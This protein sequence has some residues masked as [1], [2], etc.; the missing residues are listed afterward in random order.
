MKRILC[1][2]LAFLI[3]SIEGAYAV[4]EGILEGEIFVVTEGAEN[5]RL[6]LVEVQVFPENEIKQHIADRE[7]LAKTEMPEFTEELEPYDK[8]IAQADKEIE[9]Y[10]AGLAESRAQL[11]R[12]GRYIDIGKQ[13]QR[14]IE[15]GEAGRERAV[16]TKE[17]LAKEKEAQRARLRDGWPNSRFYFKKLPA[18]KFSTRTNSDG[19]F[20]FTIP[21]TGKFAV[22]ASATRK[23]ASKT[24]FYFWLIRISLDG[25]DSVSIILGNH[26]LA[27]SGSDDSFI[28][29]KLD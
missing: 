18:P 19:K 25:K 17:A 11:R 7:K 26:N 5:I 2:V 16:R 27:T 23:V 1:P 10:E 9:L 15:V 24:E 28:R 29:T 22:A 21:K 12:T 6:G 8:G 3:A 14:A 4:D 20:K 13:I